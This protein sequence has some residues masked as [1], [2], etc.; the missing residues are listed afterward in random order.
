MAGGGSVYCGIA[1]RWVQ[2]HPTI[3]RAFARAEARGSL[4]V[5]HS[6]TATECN[7]IE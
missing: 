2:T 3:A 7:S 1:N 6:N 4:L 5:C